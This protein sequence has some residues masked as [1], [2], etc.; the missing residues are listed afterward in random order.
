MTLLTIAVLVLALA[1]VGF[2]VWT[3]RQTRD[4]ADGHVAAFHQLLDDMTRLLITKERDAAQQVG[5]LVDRVSQAWQHPVARTDADYQDYDTAD[6]DTMLRME[7]DMEIG[8]RTDGE[9]ADSGD[10]APSAGLSEA[11]REAAA[12]SQWHRL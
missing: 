10:V 8:E 5:Q 6:P 12:Q 11:V 9:G 3:Q 1:L 7:R 2:A 4:M